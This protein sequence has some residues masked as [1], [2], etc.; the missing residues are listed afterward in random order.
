ML[1]PIDYLIW[2]AG[3]AAAIYLVVYSLARGQ[4]FR[5]LSL[6]AYILLTAITSLA[7]FFI[8]RDYGF[9]SRQYLYT[10]YYSDCLLTVLLYLV[11]MGLYSHVF[12]ELN[13]S[14]YVRGATVL[15]LLGVAGFSYLVV[16]HNAHNL[17]GKFVLEISQNL[18]FVGAVLTYGLWFVVMK[19][20]ETRARLIQLVLALGI[21]FS[22]FAALYAMRNLFPKVEILHAIPPILG[23]WLPLAWA[24]TLTKIPET[25]RL[26]PATL[27]A[28]IR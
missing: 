15:L 11:V 27:A 23:V 6:H 4:F 10:Y 19:L 21:Y 7:Q 20:R 24:Y 2:C 22:A 25:A 5:Y 26:A 28:E 18:Y 17:T 12:R 1:G 13:A 9:S 14:R 3:L 16:R 8:L